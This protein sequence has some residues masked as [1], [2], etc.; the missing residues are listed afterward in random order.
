[1][2]C[3]AEA[4]SIAAS[5]SNYQAT[6][7][8]A[9]VAGVSA[10]SFSGVA[11]HPETRT[12]YVV[13]NDNAVV[14]ELSTSGALLRS[15]ATSGFLDPEGIAYQAD[16]YFLVAEEGLANIVRIRI[17]RTGSG[18]IAKSTGSAFNLAPNQANSGIEGVSYCPAKNTVY[19]VKE[20]D[21]P[22]FYRIA[23][24]GAGNPNASFP[25]EPFNI[26]GKS[27]D[28]ADIYA[29]ND[30][31]FILVNQEQNRLE[32]LGPQGQALS[33]LPLGMS[34]PEGIAMD[35]ATGTIYVV[36]EPLEL[37]VF[38]RT[39]TRLRNA[40]FGNGS[41]SFSVLPGGMAGGARAIR[42]SLPNRTLVHIDFSAP[43]GTWTPLYDGTMDK[44]LHE[45][46]LDRRGPMAGIGFYRLSAGAFH[47]TRAIVSR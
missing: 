18:P 14:Y 37:H 46:D 39:D 5:L 35:T 47:R 24:D 28:A 10:K 41:A 43:D 27:G 9:A 4:Q 7:K 31:N 20:T 34:K 2:A 30:G 21:P 29:L 33:S 36:G 19:A 23:L 42:F 1:M 12:L 26:E 3:I 17:P 40:G 45:I 8:L 13:D 44:G 16:D 15:I 6:L 22:R 38:K 32:G 11:F 25:N